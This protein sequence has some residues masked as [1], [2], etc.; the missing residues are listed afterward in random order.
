MASRLVT[1][2]LP[3]TRLSLNP[4]SYGC[5]RMV[6]TASST[7]YVRTAKPALK[8]NPPSAK[9]STSA[10]AEALA[11]LAS[12]SAAPSPTKASS[13]GAEPF[14]GDTD[15][16][17]DAVGT[18]WSKSYYGLSSQPFPKEIADILLAPLDPLDV[19]MK[20]DGLIYLP[21]I[22]YRRVLNRAFGPGGW[23]LAPRSETNV[24]PKI[25]SR[26]YALVCLG[27]LV[28]VARGEQEFFDPSGIP[29]A[30]EAVKSNA[31]MRCCKDLGIAS[32]LWD[33]RFIREFKAKHCVA[34][35]AEHAATKQKKKLWR[36]KDQPKFDYPWKET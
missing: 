1:R 11:E 15:G 35:F 7:P 31:L 17:S 22:K 9:A 3:R 29:T 8:T 24:G 28:A 5:L 19:E 32:E 4:S 20:P 36:R 33:P 30:T 13:S 18:D 16:L 21:E 23:G 34:I 25:V 14:A 6:T 26:E 27:R 12:V 10:E 2:S